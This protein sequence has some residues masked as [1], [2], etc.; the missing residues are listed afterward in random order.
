[1][2]VS[3]SIH[4]ALAVMVTNGGDKEGSHAPTPFYRNLREG[5]SV[6]LHNIINYQHRAEMTLIY[7]EVSH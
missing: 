2:I 3:W 1:M 5:V 4:Q 7:H 6:S